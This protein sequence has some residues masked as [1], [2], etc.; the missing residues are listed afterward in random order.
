MKQNTKFLWMYVAILFSFALILI[1]FAGLSVNSETEQ[2][3]GLKDNIISLSEKNTEL[4]NEI[5]TLK[6]E[7]ET[8]NQQIGSLYTEVASLKSAEEENSAIETVLAEALDLYENKKDTECK[9]K[10]S[11]IDRTK[12]N[13]SQLY[14]YNMMMN[15]NNQ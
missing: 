14:L 10:L 4:T 9:Q 13:H 8:M 6:S 1:I 3:Q 12:L 15:I 7:K 2:K 5:N 11:E